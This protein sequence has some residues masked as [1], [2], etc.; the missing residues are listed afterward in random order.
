MAP[1]HVHTGWRGGQMQSV[2]QSRNA[3]FTSRS[4]PEWYAMTASVP[5]GAR[6]SRSA[7]SARSSPAE[8]VVHGDAH[9]LEQ[10]REVGRTRSRAER[11]A[12]RAD[13]IVA[14]REGAVARRRTISRASRIARGS[15]PY[16]RKIARELLV[17]RARSSS[18]GRVAL[19]RRAA[20]AHVERRA[21][22]EREAARRVVDLMRG[23]AEVEQDPVEAKVGDRG[24]GV[25]RG[26]VPLVGGEAT[27]SG[28]VGE[29]GARR[30][31][32][33]RIA[34][35][36]DDALDAGSSSAAA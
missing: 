35:D 4:S 7:G 32:R 6:R 9:G 11:A 20:H 21:F 18:V 25:D 23:D 30:R 8:L 17:A 16:S 10:P 3:C 33:V 19:A 2:L 22:A 12:D 26:V 1:P 28:G 27:A 15:S 31:E 34:I 24:D 5:P 36:A 13:E 14:R 29:P